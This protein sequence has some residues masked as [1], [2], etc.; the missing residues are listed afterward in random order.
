MSLR[1]AIKRSLDLEIEKKKLISEVTPTKEEKMTKQS[2]T[3]NHRG[4]QHPARRT[5]I[6]I[7]PV[8]LPQIDS[9]IRNCD[10]SR[11]DEFGFVEISAGLLSE[12]LLAEIRQE[13]VDKVTRYQEG[14][15]HSPN[16]KRQR[17]Q[18][19]GIEEISN[20]LQVDVSDDLLHK[21]DI[22][23]Q[24]SDLARDAMTSVFGKEGH[25]GTKSNYNGFVLE[26]PKFL[27]T[28]PGSNPQLPHADD[29]CNSC[30][31][32]V[33][34]LRDK[35]EPTLAASYNGVNK[36][37]PTGITVSCNKCSR[38]QML[39]DRDYR[40]GV[41]LTDEEWNCG[42]CNA[43]AIPYNFEGSMVNSFGE[44]LDADA[45]NLCH[46]YCGKKNVNA[47]DGIFSL[48]TLIHR[49]PGCSSSATEIRYML[50]F[51]LRPQYSNMTKAGVDYHR[52]NPDLQI[53]APCILFNQ[54]TNVKSI[55]ANSGCNL[56]GY[57]RTFVGK[58]TASLMNE[59]ALLKAENKYL[60][61]KIDPQQMMDN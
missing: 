34:H 54:F 46:S 45:P 61:E 33:I 29:H 8:E 15:I 2:S 13:A 18:P 25:G 42:D 5:S 57:L 37:Y 12:L 6:P 39:P 24:T 52:Y 30:I 36:D 23:V 7:L 49:G 32:G 35:Q 14:K 31:M 3:M 48:P 4:R 19:K 43:P 20:S 10:P 28:L 56:E 59:V 27:V 47:G 58:E 21:I 53:H 17:R 16:A 44:L 55:Y 50:F 60:K 26:T 9:C 38:T 41:H 1:I 11:I 40:R 22:E 51:T